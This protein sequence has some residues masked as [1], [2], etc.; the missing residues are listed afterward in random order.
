MN[1]NKLL[2]KLIFDYK[3]FFD[4]QE[5]NDYKTEMSTFLKENKDLSDDEFFKK[6]QD[7]FHMT[8]SIDNAISR[9]YLM[10]I[11]S[12]IK[13]IKTIIVIYFILSIIAAIVFLF[14]QAV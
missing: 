4:N 9:S 5:V 8:K 14:S 7:T 12:D 2:G 3:M 10:R 1:R 13:T 6:F 11:A